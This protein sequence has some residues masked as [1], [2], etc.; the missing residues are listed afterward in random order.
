MKAIETVYRGYRFR[1][2]LEA[3]W[4][5]F[6]DALGVE[7]FYEH[8]DFPTDAGRYLPD[9][10]LP[11]LGTIVEV[12]PYAPSERE[13]RKAQWIVSH[14]GRAVLF[15]LSDPT[16]WAPWSGYD[17]TDSSSGLCT[18]GPDDQIGQIGIDRRTGKPAICVAG[19][20][21][22]RDYMTPWDF[23][24]CV[25]PGPDF[26]VP[27]TAIQAFRSARFEFGAKS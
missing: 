14:A 26:S 16:K 15:V 10:W 7:W 3:R 24:Y 18:F 19:D 22:R 21:D 11:G 27:E 8:E 2:R 20:N 12:K 13:L 9:F 17:S 6:F 1:S 25:L 5:V 4:A 23:S